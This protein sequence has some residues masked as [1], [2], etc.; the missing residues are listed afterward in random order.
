MAWLIWM[1]LFR[2]Q[3]ASLWKGCSK[4][5]GTREGTLSCWFLSHSLKILC[6]R[7]DLLSGGNDLFCCWKD[8]FISFPQDIMLSERLIKLREWLINCHWNDLF[9]LP[10]DIICRKDKLSWGNDLLIVIGMTYSCSLEILCCRKDKLSWGKDLL[11][12]R[13]DLFILFPRDH[14]KSRQ[15]LILW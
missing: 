12:H 10:W 9:L 4:S 1:T 7:N 13:N 6:C 3:F 14:I 15:Q 2:S 11:C 8:L 5:Y